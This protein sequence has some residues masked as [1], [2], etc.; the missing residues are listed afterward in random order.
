V[1][2]FVARINDSPHVVRFKSKAQLIAKNFYS[3][4][5]RNRFLFDRC[6]G[7]REQGVKYL[8]FRL[9]SFPRP[10]VTWSP[11]MK[12]ERIRSKNLLTLTPKLPPL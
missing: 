1:N 12:I 8:V 3:V 10:F 2:Q 9:K 5:V 11:T 7:Q 6:L 4:A